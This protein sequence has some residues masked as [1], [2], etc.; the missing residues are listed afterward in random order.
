MQAAKINAL[1][2]PVWFI[3]L[4]S[5]LLCFRVYAKLTQSTAPVDKCVAWITPVQLEQMAAKARW[6]QE[7]PSVL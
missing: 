1:T 4:V 7:R 5:W 3:V 6:H 2:I